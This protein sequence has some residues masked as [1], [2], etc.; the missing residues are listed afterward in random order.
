MRDG[1]ICDDARISGAIWIGQIYRE[2]MG[3]VIAA[4]GATLNVHILF[5]LSRPEVDCQAWVV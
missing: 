1:I 2:P 4:E 5:V 3:Q